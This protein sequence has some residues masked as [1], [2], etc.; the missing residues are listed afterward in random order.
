M[1][2]IKNIKYK[3]FIISAIFLYTFI[4]YIMP[5]SCVIL[6]LTG[7]PCPGCGMTRALLAALQLDFRTA[8][9]YHPMFWSVS[10]LF[11]CIIFDGKLFRKRYINVL[12]YAFLFLGYIINWINS[13]NF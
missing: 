10:L 13:I 7:F 5:G 2:K 3:I 4:I 8:F 11:L 6:S 1:P 12:F 9:A